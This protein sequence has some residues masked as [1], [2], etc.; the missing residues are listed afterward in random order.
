MSDNEDDGSVSRSDVTDYE[1]LWDHDTAGSPTLAV[2]SAVA[3]LDR[4]DSSELPPLFD[5]IDPEALNALFPENGDRSARRVNFRYCGYD[6]TVSPSVIRVRSD[7][8]V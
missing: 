8:E 5:S 6:V 2:V 1:R 7:A 3:E 4:V